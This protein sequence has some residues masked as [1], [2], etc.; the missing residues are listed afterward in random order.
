[1]TLWSPPQFPHKNCAAFSQ[2]TQIGPDKNAYYHELFLR[3]KPLLA[4]KIQRQMI[5]GQGP[6]KRSVPD[7]EPNFYAMASLPDENHHIDN[8]AS[9]ITPKHPQVVHAVTTGVN[10]VMEIGP[11][12]TSEQRPLAP[13]PYLPLFHDCDPA[14]NPLLVAASR[15]LG[16]F[17]YAGRPLT[18]SPFPFFSLLPYIAT[19]FALTR[20]TTPHIASV[21]EEAIRVTT[22]GPCRISSS[23]RNNRDGRRP[24]PIPPTC[25][26][27]GN[28]SDVSHA[29]SDFIRSFA[30]QECDKKGFTGL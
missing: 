26:R 17:D 3:G 15:G 13:V 22:D 2:L 10:R 25:Y 9:K 21:I 8:M 16:R 29:V 20:G 5:K 23:L 14:C 18:T 1:M 12:P 28:L 24:P 27:S 11:T 19:P 7:T 30:S 6:R 4:R